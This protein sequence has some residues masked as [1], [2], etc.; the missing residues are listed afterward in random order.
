MQPEILH[1]RDGQVGL[2]HRVDAPVESEVGPQVTGHVD[3]VGGLLHLVAQMADVLEVGVVEQDDRFLGQQAFERYPGVAD[4]AQAFGSHHAHTQAG[5]FG[6]FEGVL[7][8]QAVERFAHR[9]RAGAEGLGQ[10]A[11]GQL[12]ARLEAAAHQRVADLPVDLVLQGIAG[13]LAHGGQEDRLIC[14]E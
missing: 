10:T 1:G 5:G 3:A 8:T 11:D 7:G 14:H 4:L 6:D 13:N 12:L 9:H 2:D